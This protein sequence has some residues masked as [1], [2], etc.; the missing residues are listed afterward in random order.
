M[1]P[2]DIIKI[3]EARSV[4]ATA[5]RIELAKTLAAAGRPM[6]LSE[7]ES[8]MP[9][10]DKSNIFRSL[11]TFRDH[12]LVHV[13]EDGSGGQ[14]YELCLSHHEDHD[15]DRHPHF[16]CESCM[17]TYCLE[18]MRIPQVEVPAGYHIHSVNYVLK[19]ICPSCSKK[20]L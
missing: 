9:T 10:V 19:G 15:D 1:T 14:R 3:L 13:I 11:S 2:S 18:D 12:H 6:S 17:K 5:N 8:E 20:G 16:Y 7:L 4:R